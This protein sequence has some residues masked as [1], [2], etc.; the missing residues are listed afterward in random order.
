MLGRPHGL[1]GHLPLRLYHRGGAAWRATPPPLDVILRDGRGGARAAHLVEA[2]ATAGDPLVR[3]AEVA[4]REAA[5]ALTGHELAWPR[6]A[7]PP[8]GPGEHY[9]EDLLGRRASDEAGRPIGTIV[10]T[11]WNGAHDVLVVRA[12]RGG[13][14]LVPAVAEFLRAVDPAAG[15]VVLDLHE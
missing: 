14:R 6:A 3:F 12:E 11:F 5:A 2:R 15:H 13:E 10:G 4:D 7:L 8:L 1:R 9:V